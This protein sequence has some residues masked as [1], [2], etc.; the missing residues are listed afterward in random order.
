MDVIVVLRLADGGARAF[1]VG[2]GVGIDQD[3]CFLDRPGS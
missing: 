3:Y 2:C 1:Y